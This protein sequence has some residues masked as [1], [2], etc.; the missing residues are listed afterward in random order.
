MDLSR[1]DACWS[2]TILAVV[3][4]S[5]S[6]PLA[7]QS[8]K[9]NGLL[10]QRGL[11]RV[12][13]LLVTPQ[14]RI[15][16]VA[17][18]EQEEVYGLYTVPLDGS[19]AP[20]KLSLPGSVWP[21]VA[22][23]SADGTRVV[24]ITTVPGDPRLTLW[25]VPPDGS[26]LPVRL[27]VPSPDGEVK[28]FRLTADSARVV[29]LSTAGSTALHTVPIDGSG[30]PVLIA[31]VAVD[32]LYDL[33]PDSARVAF[34]SGGLFSA[35][36]D[37]S[38]TPVQLGN[39]SE[40]AI[41]PSSDRVAFK[42]AR[43]LHGV[44]IDGS[45]PALPLSPMPSSPQGDLRSF[46]FTPDGNRLLFRVD[47]FTTGVEL[48][49]VPADGSSAAVDLDGT[50]ATGVTSFVV[51]PDSAR[52]LYMEAGRDELLVAPVDGSSGPLAL[53]AINTMAYNLGISASTGRALFEMWGGSAPGLHTFSVPLDASA[54]P[55]LVADGSYLLAP[56][57]DRVLCFT[58]VLVNAPVDGSAPPVVLTPQVSIN[59]GGPGP[60]L[61]RLTDDGEH[62]VFG[63]ADP[64]HADVR[65][66]AVPFDGS[67]P[68]VVLSPGGPFVN[69]GDVLDFR[70]ADGGARVV[71][72]GGQAIYDVP[73]LFTARV[74]GH[75]APTRLFPARSFALSRFEV[76]PDGGRVVEWRTFYALQSAPVDGTGPAVELLSSNEY[77]D[78]EFA[79]FPDG[80]H[81]AARARF[82]GREDL[83]V[84]ASDGSAPPIRV[85]T[86]VEDFGIGPNGAWGVARRSDQIVGID[87]ALNQYTLSPPLGPGQD[88]S[89]PLV[90]S[91]TGKVLYRRFYDPTDDFV[92]MSTPVNGSASAV[93]LA[94]YC[95]PDFAAAPGSV[96]VVFR[97]LVDDELYR[98][99][100]DRST[101]PMR[102]STSRRGAE[103]FRFDPSGT[104]VLFRADRDLGGIYEL[105]EA[106][107][108][109]SAPPRQVNLDPVPLGDVELL[110]LQPYTPD[111]RSILYVADQ[112]ERNAHDLY[113]S[114]DGG[115][116]LRL[117]V[118]RPQRSVQTDFAITPDGLQVVYRADQDAN[119]R[120][121]LYA[122]PLDGTKA[123]RRINGPLVAGGDV[124]RFAVD[125]RNQVVVY[126]ADQDEDEV[127]ELYSTP[128]PRRIRRAPEPTP[129]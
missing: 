80:K 102:V 128:L 45:G 42:D 125:P 90:F 123:P 69:A 70:F 33:S 67:G 43:R 91:A 119:E 71:Y 81:V 25:S 117:N 126:L 65:V 2:R 110:G 108:D 60:Y 19:S 118:H 124:T 9:L 89:S 17:D 111:G 28:S 107:L 73:E 77:I 52:V 6:G 37:G 54:P 104:R 57:G 53:T 86:F 121:E 56:G 116:P 114:R 93:E 51:S 46:G 99:P 88:L 41:S 122:V 79:I 87:S 11:G 100:A 129:R 101:W 10:A 20:V 38:G 4:A 22:R 5:S 21:G 66:R 72:Q 75:P 24:Y 92:L 44:P 68:M 26:L 113:V 8:H 59:G 7:A 30:A 105:F 58:S 35:P 34:A 61:V 74:E 97:S 76:T 27:D 32:A 78:K 120:Y 112:D 85:T 94:H 82:G 31:P 14:E 48:F 63:A 39:A 95:E 16:Y 103:D 96:W 83:F 55:V 84:I 29:F 127:F 106:P 50:R 98:V 115:P 49:S 64:N 62:V 13:D 15:V 47:L 23:T 18:N 36:A 3:L 12:W 109:G 1:Y 40:F